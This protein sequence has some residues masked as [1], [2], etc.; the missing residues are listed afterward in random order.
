VERKA[1]TSL[2]IEA[3]VDAY[4]DA[5]FHFALARVQ[6]QETAEDLVQETFLAAVR[7]QE[8]FKGL[9]SEKTWLF[10]ILKH[11][12]IDHYR[13]TK[14]TR[15]LEARADDAADIETCFN[16]RGAWRERPGHWSTDPGKAHETREFLDHFYRCLADL[17]QRTAEA[18]VYREIDGLGT[19]AI[20]R[21]LEITAANCW[22]MLYRARML[23]RKC[24]EGHGFHPQN[25]GQER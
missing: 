3:W 9:S 21:R 19:E 10:G 8:R 2:N 17:P 13:R 18:F 20:C 11:K 1:R 4:G 7:S 24:L 6:K 25:A 15:L 23:L 14:T 12:I 5:L 22:T 16:A